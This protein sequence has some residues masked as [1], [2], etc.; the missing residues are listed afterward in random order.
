VDV[1]GERQF[2]AKQNCLG[3]LFDLAFGQ[4]GPQAVIHVG[5][6]TVCTQ[7]LVKVLERLA[8]VEVRT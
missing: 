3:R 1:L 6:E 7:A 4:T 8:Q 5:L 2:F